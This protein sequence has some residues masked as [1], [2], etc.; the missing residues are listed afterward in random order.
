MVMLLIAALGLAVEPEI[1]PLPEPVVL[2]RILLVVG[3]RIITLSDLQ[4]EM[5][6]SQRDQ[7]PVPVL[8]D[9]QQE[10]LQ[11]LAERAI[12]RGLAGEMEI[13]QPSTREVLARLNALKAQWT[14]EEYNDFTQHHGLDETQLS[15]LMYTRMVVERYIHRNIGRVIESTGGSEAAY[16][17]RYDTWIAAEFERN[18]PR[19]VER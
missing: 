6:L 4:L 3:E 5:V 2:D 1:E 19:Y 13:Y 7:S 12:I 9:R 18:P 17:Q 8:Q 11:V 15:S 14:T 16:Q 10:P